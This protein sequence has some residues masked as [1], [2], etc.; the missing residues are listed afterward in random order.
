MVLGQKNYL[1]YR[2]GIHAFY[3]PFRTFEKEWASL[4]SQS[5]SLGPHIYTALQGLS[6]PRLFRTA[7]ISA[8]LA[9][10]YSGDGSS[11]RFDPIAPPTTPCRIAYIQHIEE[12]VR[13]KPHVLIAY[14]HNFYMA[15]FAGGKILA[16]RILAAKEFFPVVVPAGS[17]EEAQMFSMNM[18]SFPVE[19]GREEELR[20]KFKTAMEALEGNLSEEE[21]TGLFI[22]C[23]R[24]L[25]T[26]V[27]KRYHRRVSYH[28]SYEREAN[29][30]AR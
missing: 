18:Y 30:R 26:N 10:L 7:A 22:S 16:K 2:E 29:H 6:D 20:A 24:L 11:I 1:L 21:K 9:Y 15:L 3:Y 5:S 13:K 17:Y 25:H 12:V 27:G 28:L 4:L 8:D 23:S 14:A 19:K